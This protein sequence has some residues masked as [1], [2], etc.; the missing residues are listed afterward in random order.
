MSNGYNSCTFVGNL[1]RDPETKSSQGGTVYCKSSIAVNSGFGDKEKCLF[2]NFTAFGKTA[3]AI[4]KFVG[5][6]D[7]V[8]LSGE[9]QCDEVAQDD[10]SK[11]YYWS[12]VVQRCLFL[13]TKGDK[14]KDAGTKPSAAPAQAHQQASPEVD[15][16]NI[17]F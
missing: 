17:P 12:L 1:V 15:P 6:G 8:L 7:R 16:D 10:G 13:Q 9:L 5:K 2:L 3:E 11:R 4:Q 14:K